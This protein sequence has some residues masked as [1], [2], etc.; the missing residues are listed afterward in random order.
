MAYDYGRDHGRDYRREPE[1]D[2]VDLVCDALSRHG[3]PPLITDRLL[4]TI[5]TYDTEDPM[6]ALS[7]ALDSIFTFQPLPLGRAR[8]AVHADRS[9]RRRQDADHRQARHPRHA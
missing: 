7:A 3:T 1:V 8:A 5:A 2:V 4:N 6:D 9:A